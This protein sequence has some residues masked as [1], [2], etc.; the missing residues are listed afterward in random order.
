[1]GVEGNGYTGAV[2]SAARATTSKQALVTEMN[3]VK[4]ADGDACILEW[5]FYFFK[6]VYK[7]SF[8]RLLIFFY[9]EL[10]KKVLTKIGSA[11]IFMRVAEVAELV[12]ALGSGSSGGFLVEVRVFSSAPELT[13]GLLSSWYAALFFMFFLHLRGR[14]HFLLY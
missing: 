2:C 13:N 8:A 12:D 6:F 14:I 3:T 9:G 5:V 1:M 11:S 7:F 10:T 4:V